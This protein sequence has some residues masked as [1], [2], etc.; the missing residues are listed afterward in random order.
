MRFLAIEKLY[1]GNMRKKYLLYAIPLILTSL[2]TQSYQMINSMM[3]GKFIG[4]EAFAATGST[5]P[6][7]ELI[8]SVFWGYHTGVSI[9]VAIL[10]GRGDN[11]RMLNVI[12]INFL[13]GTVVAILI[14]VMCNV[15]HAPLFKLLNIEDSLSSQAY[16]YFGTYTMGLA[17]LQLNWGFSY[18]AHGL[19]VT[20]MPLLVSFASGIT[21]VLG[22]YISLSVLD[23]GVAGCAISTILASVFACIVYLIKYISIFRSM[24]LK[25]G[26]IKW[27]KEDFKNSFDYGVPTLVQQLAMYSGSAVVSPLINKCGVAAIS[28][29]NIANKAKG[30]IASV[31]Q[32]SNKANTNFVAQTMGA[33]KIY[34]IKKGIKI[35]MTQTM[36][37]FTPLMLLFMIFARP[38]AHLF[39]DSAKDVE[40]INYSVN[41]MR[42]LLP[43]IVFNVVNNFFHG[44]FRATGSG[45]IM[46]VSTVIYSAAMI[47]YSYLLCSL[48]PTSLRIYGIYIGLA[49]AWLTEAAFASLIYIRGKWKTEEYKRLESQR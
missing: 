45:K 4:S 1:E 34:K 37:I 32:S 49:L 19:G 44:V 46:L 48:L 33:G 20:K 47:I 39:L 9:Y 6:I 21:N 42:Y 28:G 12:K 18:I 31:Y 26:G 10:F 8:D 40:S 16:A 43:F 41:I 36:A 7:I 24:G 3:I 14:G 11:K 27:D 17:A 29:L 13:L 2:L 23:M 30:I 38:F 25:L 5:A 22:N 35:G 15:F